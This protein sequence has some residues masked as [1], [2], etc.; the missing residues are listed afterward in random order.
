MREYGI[1]QL[2]WRAREALRMRVSMSAMGS[3]I[4]MGLP[5]R[6]RHARDLSCQGE[7]A[8]A[9]ATQREATDEGARTAAQLAAV[10]RLHFESRRAL[11]LRDHRFLCQMIPPEVQRLGGRCLSRR[12][13]SVFSRPSGGGVRR[14]VAE[15]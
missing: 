14:G 13:I 5:A 15:P 4:V 11:R 7:L 3:L 10:V 2:G 12:D 6:F 9:D 1:S 8:E